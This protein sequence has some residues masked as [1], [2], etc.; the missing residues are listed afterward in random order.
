MTGSL[1]RYLNG[2]G[3]IVSFR[4]WRPG[5][6]W[7]ISILSRYAEGLVGRGGDVTLPRALPGR[8]E[9]EDEPSASA[10]GSA[11]RSFSATLA[12]FL[13]ACEDVLSPHP[14]LC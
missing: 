13:S 4:G 10:A 8:L 6:G 11:P 9:G 2:G 5:A 12:F 1:S 7:A 3:S 14:F